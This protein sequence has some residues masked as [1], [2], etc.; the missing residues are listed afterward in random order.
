MLYEILIVSRKL[1]KVIPAAAQP[2]HI[3]HGIP[4]D[5]RHQVTERL[6]RVDG[7]PIVWAA[8]V[9]VEQDVPARVTVET[10]IAWPDVG[11]VTGGN[12]FLEAFAEL[13]Y[14]LI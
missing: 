2:H 13:L 1:R 7:V 6:G 5:F 11:A 8:P 9:R 14:D 3:L 12:P 4:Q 10:G